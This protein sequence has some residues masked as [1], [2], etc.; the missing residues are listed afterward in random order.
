V[1]EGA[2]GVVGGW[3]RWR[4]GSGGGGGA[5]ACGWRRPGGG[6]L[7]EAARACERVK[8]RARV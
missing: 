1:V 4:C 2:A 8:E 5:A 7:A 6:G 3:W